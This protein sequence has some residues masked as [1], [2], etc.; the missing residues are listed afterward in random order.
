[1]VG[2]STTDSV[3]SVDMSVSKLEQRV[4]DMEAW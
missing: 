4:K 1:M 2:W 3:D